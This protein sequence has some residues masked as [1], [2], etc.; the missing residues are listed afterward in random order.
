V[1][2]KKLFLGTP[3]TDILGNAIIL[4]DECGLAPIIEK[5]RNIAELKVS[6][7]TPKK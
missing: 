3:I 6:E 5:C 4:S 1:K 2:K 7:L